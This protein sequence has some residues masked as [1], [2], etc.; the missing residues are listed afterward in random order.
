MPEKLSALHK[1][2]Q[3]VSGKANIWMEGFWLRD[4]NSNPGTK[5][6]WLDSVQNA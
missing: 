2:T 4:S 1:A 6:L 3:L 5:F